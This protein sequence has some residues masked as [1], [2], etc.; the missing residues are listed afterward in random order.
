MAVPENLV[1]K[2]RSAKIYKKIIFK[3]HFKIWVPLRGAQG[4]ALVMPRNQ[5]GEIRNET[6]FRRFY[7]AKAKFGAK[8]ETKFLK[9][10]FAKYEIFYEIF[11][12]NFA[13]Y[14]IFFHIFYCIIYF[15]YFL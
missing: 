11:K 4:C 12:H 13:K 5:S 8:Y 14:E 1:I 3:N 15:S 10:N 9:R 6:K 7:F 2:K